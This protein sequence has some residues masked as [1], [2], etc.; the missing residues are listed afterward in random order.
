[1]KEFVG[2]SGWVDA[3]FAT[4]TA[5]DGACFHIQFLDKHGSALL[6]GEGVGVKNP[7]AGISNYTFKTPLREVYQAHV[8]ISYCGSEHSVTNDDFLDYQ[9]FILGMNGRAVDIC[10]DFSDLDGFEQELERF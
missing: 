1:P 10:L 8:V 4:D 9:R 2:N 5:D 6:A 3:A 7:V